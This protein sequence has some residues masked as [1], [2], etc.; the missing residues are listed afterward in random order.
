[1]QVL[2]NEGHKDG[3]D[4]LTAAG[5]NFALQAPIRDVAKQAGEWNEARLIVNGS[6]VEHWLNGVKLLEYEL[7][8]D[9]WLRSVGKSKFKNMPAYGKARSGHIALQDHGDWVAFR[10][11]EIRIIK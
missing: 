7:G 3:R 9:E 2:D 4:P 10:N 11:I 1:M 5:S 6:H 8:S